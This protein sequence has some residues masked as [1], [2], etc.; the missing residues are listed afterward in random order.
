MALE[1]TTDYKGS[2]IGPIQ[3]R[4][5]RRR[6]IPIAVINSEI[7]EGY[8]LLIK[9]TE[10]VLMGEVAVTNSNGIR[11]VF[12]INTADNDLEIERSPQEIIPFEYYKLPGEDFDEDSADEDYSPLVNKADEV[13]KNLRL[14]HLN[15]EEKDHVLDIVRDFPDK[16]YLPGEPLT[17]T[18]LVKHKIH[19]LD[20]VPINTRPYRFLPSQREEVERVIQ[21]MK[22]VG[23]I[24][25][26]KSHNSP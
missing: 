4:A 11:H 25:N 12:A 7:K 17:P 5:R 6:V 1:N 8:I 22:T 16:F 19:T 13:I 21:K 2:M 18:Y 20:D 9:T 10:G 14:G 3:V 24:Q 26:S 15:P 23:A